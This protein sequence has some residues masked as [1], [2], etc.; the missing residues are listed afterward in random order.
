MAFIWCA[1]SATGYDDSHIPFMATCGLDFAFLV[2]FIVLA[3]VLGGPLSVTTCS[4]ISTDTTSILVPLDQGS[5]ISYLNFVGSGRTV[6]YEL[7]AVW[8][9]TIALAILFLSSAVSALFL[10]LGRRKQVAALAGP[11]A[12]PPTSAPGSSAL[13][14]DEE[15]GSDLDVE[16]MKH[17]L[18]IGTAHSY[19]DE[20]KYG[21]PE[22][23]FGPG[24]PV[25]YAGQPRSQ[26]RTL[27]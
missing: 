27:A 7:Q 1:L 12:P 8:G 11:R 21:A 23:Q 14:F 20:D 17:G 16:S 6:C 4:D 25:V 22:L 9:L 10:F 3:G 13:K 26:S 2:P 5:S 15:Y 24:V 19:E 18:G